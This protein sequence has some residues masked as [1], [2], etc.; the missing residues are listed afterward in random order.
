MTRAFC[1][2]RFST[3]LGMAA[4]TQ[5][6]S[7]MASDAQV[8][9][10]VRVALAAPRDT[11]WTENRGQFPSIFHRFPGV[12]DGQAM[13]SVVWQ[14]YV[15]MESFTLPLVLEGVWTTKRDPINKGRGDE[16]SVESLKASVERN[17][18][19]Q[20]FRGGAW[21]LGGKRNM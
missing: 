20:N 16:A 10:A 7:D 1:V 11:V 6:A 8:S 19:I 17:G 13:Q 12:T 9:E 18:I 21:V 14:H 5:G 3:Q 2:R 4:S 15:L